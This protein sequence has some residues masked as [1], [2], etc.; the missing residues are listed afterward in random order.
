MTVGIA[1]IA[2]PILPDF[3]ENS[4]LGFNDAERSLAQLR[5]KEDAFGMSDVA[6][7]DSSSAWQSLKSALGDYKAWVM[8][9]SLTAMVIALS[10]N[11]FFP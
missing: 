5:M 8:A 11:Q 7:A 4:R 2:I 3:P 1:F 10:F 6:G 9:L